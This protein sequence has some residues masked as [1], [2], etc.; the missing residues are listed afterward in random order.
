[1]RKDNQLH[2]EAQDDQKAVEKKNN[3]VFKPRHEKP[4]QKTL[5]IRELL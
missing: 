5:N 2:K 1:M 3:I 4:K